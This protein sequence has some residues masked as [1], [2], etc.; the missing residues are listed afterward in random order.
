MNTLQCI[1]RLTAI[2]FFIISCQDN[3]VEKTNTDIYG[4]W[5]F[6]EYS[7]DEIVMTKANELQNDNSGFVFNT[8]GT[9][10][11]RK[12]AG[13]C[14]TPPI[15]YSNFNG[16]W[17]TTTNNLLQVNVAYWGGTERYNIKTTYIDGNTLKFIKLYPE[18]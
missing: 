8:N 13:W 10:I 3:P 14:G 11:E 2:C 9:M 5:V 12:N 7:N 6:K 4:T 16:N 15:S 17:E 18:Q 1:L